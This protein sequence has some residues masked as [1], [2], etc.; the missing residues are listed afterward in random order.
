MNFRIDPNFTPAVHPSLS[1]EVYHA[2]L[3]AVGSSQL[4]RILKSPA[5]FKAQFGTSPEESDAFRFGTLVHLAVLEPQAF[6]ERCV[7]MPEFSGTTK[8]G[9]PSTRSAEATAK[10]NEWLAAMKLE[11]RIACSQEDM[12]A[13]QAITAAVNKH[14]DAKKLLS[15]GYA[16]QSIYFA[17]E[18][19]GVVNKVRP[20]WVNPGMRALVDIKTTQDCSLDAFSKTI[21]NYR[22]DFQMAM[23]SEGVRKTLFRPERHAYIVIEKSAPYEVAVYYADEQMLAMGMNDYNRANAMLAKCLK[24]NSWDSYQA[25]AETIGLPAYSYGQITF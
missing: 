25:M 10:K 20:D 3:T 7:V 4:K 23:Y 24:T 18:Q 11:S 13:I 19:T 17:H 9:R 21:W 8:D 5:S 1:A 22:Y 14:P 16:E 12:N 15:E 6:R 2:D